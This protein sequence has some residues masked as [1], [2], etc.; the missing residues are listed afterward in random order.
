MG[1]V[2]KLKPVAVP[3]ASVTVLPD[4]RPLTPKQERFA[5]LF[6]EQGNATA[7]YKASYDVSP[8]AKPEALHVEA[9]RML[10]DP[11]IALRVSEIEAEALAATQ[12]TVGRLASEGLA[13]LEMAKA[14]GDVRAGTAVLAVLGKLH[15]RLSPTGG[16]GK[17][18]D[19]MTDAEL[20]A[21][22]AGRM[23][24]MGQWLE[25]TLA[26]GK[27]KQ[28]EEDKA[29]VAELLSKLAASEDA[30]VAAKAL[31]ILQ[32]IAGRSSEAN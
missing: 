1:E 14:G 12:L 11:R 27:Q 19:E 31:P 30:S 17:S 3:S 18:L 8:D 22:A 24:P 13:L 16:T 5:R 21:I 15:E 4:R 7:A 29:R 25:E 26:R 32:Q 23:T 20:Q 28:A 10:A 9:S 6:V 2:A